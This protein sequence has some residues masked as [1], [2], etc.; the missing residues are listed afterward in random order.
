MTDMYS[1]HHVASNKKKNL[2]AENCLIFS[3][4]ILFNP[5]CGWMDICFYGDGFGIERQSQEKKKAKIKHNA[6]KYRIYG[7]SS[8]KTM[9]G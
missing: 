4:R 2:K 5:F 9:L 1:I 7:G 3:Q 8:T 6:L